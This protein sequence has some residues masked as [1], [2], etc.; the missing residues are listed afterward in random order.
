MNLLSAKLSLLSIFM[1]GVLPIPTL[2]EEGQTS[3]CQMSPSEKPDSPWDYRTR[4]DRLELVENR[5][6]TRQVELLIRGE[7]T[8]NLAADIGY[9]LR[10]FPNHHRALASLVRYSDTKKQSSF[11]GMTYSVDCYLQRAVNFK[12][13]DP[14]VRIIYAS[15]LIK[16]KRLEKAR[17]QLAYLEEYEDKNS[18]LKYNMGLIF[19]DI[20]DYPKSL[21]YAHEAYSEGFPLQG[22]KN[23]LVKGG[24]W[25]DTLPTIPK[26]IDK[27]VESNQNN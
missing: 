17:E 21:S 14:Q 26:N 16:N 8:S 9:T 6:F 18:A 19:F 10:M 1:V 20:G 4:K 23:K 5:H 15:H 3:Q 13:D 22:L 27:A 2:A 11:S 7:S 24:K 25:K 12:E